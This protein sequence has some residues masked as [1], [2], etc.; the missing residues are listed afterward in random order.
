M[1]FFRPYHRRDENPFCAVSCR[2]FGTVGQD[3]LLHFGPAAADAGGT[4]NNPKPH[5][6]RHLFRRLR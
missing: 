4:G 5:P 3:S 2:L 6:R 1:F